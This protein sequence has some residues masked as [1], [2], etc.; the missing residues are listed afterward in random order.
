MRK[1]TDDLALTDDEIAILSGS[2]TPDLVRQFV[3]R[4]QSSVGLRTSAYRKVAA[5]ARAER[6]AM[7]EIRLLQI[8]RERIGEDPM[9]LPDVPALARPEALPPLPASA[10]DRVMAVGGD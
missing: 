8:A 9:A 5:L 10:P 1:K 2:R 6:E 7:T 3:A 4:Q